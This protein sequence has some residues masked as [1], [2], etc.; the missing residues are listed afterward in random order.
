M[1]SFPL[2]LVFFKILE[3]P[4]EDS[5]WLNYTN[6]MVF[7]LSD[8]CIYLKRNDFGYIFHSHFNLLYI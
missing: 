8:F 5:K 4:C 3:P 7:L 1:I 2:P 6:I